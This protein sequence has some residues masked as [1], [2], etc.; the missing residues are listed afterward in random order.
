MP[1]ITAPALPCAV[2]SAAI[3]APNWFTP[4]MIAGSTF[5]STGSMYG[6]K[7]MRAPVFPIWWMSCTISGCQALC[8]RSTVA[9]VSFCVNAYQSRLLS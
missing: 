5:G 3:H 4:A 6:G 1:L 8:A 9:C 2:T 7:K